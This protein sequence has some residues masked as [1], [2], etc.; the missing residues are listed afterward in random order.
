MADLETITE[1]I[2]ALKQ[3]A[4][5]V[6]AAEVVNLLREDTVEVSGIHHQGAFNPFSYTVTE[7]MLSQLSK[8]GISNPDTLSRVKGWKVEMPKKDIGP[9]WGITQSLR[10]YAES[11]YISGT[12]HMRAA[13]LSEFLEK[14]AKARE[15]WEDGV[16]HLKD[17]Y[18]SLKESFW[19]TAEDALQSFFKEDPFI[20]KEVLKDVKAS[21]PSKESYIARLG[22]VVNIRKPGGNFA[23]FKPEDAR[24]I[25][26]LSAEATKRQVLEITQQTLQ[27]IVVETSAL[28]SNIESA[29]M[30]TITTRQ[31]MQFGKAV[32][33]ANG[34][35]LFSNPTI[36]SFIGA[37]E[38]IYKETKALD[39]ATAQADCEDLLAG[40]LAFEK[41][42]EGISL[43]WR[44]CP[45]NRGVLE[46][47][48]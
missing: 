44:N 23:F 20:A 35:N 11:R 19:G 4:T 41:G 15:R 25:E 47:L 28:Y 29:G 45:L 8:N 1:G 30:G 46:S 39:Y 34:D 42:I 2:A 38:E 24:T 9:F 48:I 3:K 5:T 22:L 26:E 12:R 10:S 21:T 13:E 14:V 6:N 18:D 37:M 43:N 32:K 7:A 27:N 17:T 36:G 31:L 16:K 40:V 33:R